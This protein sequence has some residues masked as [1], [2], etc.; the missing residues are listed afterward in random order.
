M[1]DI[2]MLAQTSAFMKVA[3]K[4]KSSRAKAQEKNQ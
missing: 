2:Q 3:V 4:L 1:V